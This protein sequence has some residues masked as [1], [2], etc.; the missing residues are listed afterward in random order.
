MHKNIKK[1]IFFSSSLFL[2]ILFILIFHFSIKNIPFVEEANGKLIDMKY[3]H[4][5]NGENQY[6]NVTY[7][8]GKDITAIRIS[9]L[10]DLNRI[11]RVNYIPDKFIYPD[12]ISKDTQIVDL[13]KP[14]EFSKKGTLIF[15][16]L[17]LDP[18]SEDFIEQSNALSKYKIGDYWKFT[19]SLPQIFSASNIYLKSSL[20]AKNGTIKD[21]DFIEYTTSYDE[22]SEKFAAETKDTNIDL[23]F[24]TRREGIDSTIRS[25][26]TIT[27][28]YEAENTSFS[29]MKDYPVIGTNEAI[30]QIQENNYTL[31]LS[32]AFLAIIVL[33]ILLVLSILKHSK[34]FISAILWMTGIILILFAYFTV[35]QTTTLPLLWKALSSSA[36]FLTISGALLGIEIIKKKVWIKYIFLGLMC[37]GALLAF[38]CPYVPFHIATILTWLQYGIRGIGIISIISLLILLIFKKDNFQDYFQLICSTLIAIETFTSLFLPEKFPVSL[39]PSFW[40]NVVT[41]FIT[42]ISVFLIFRETEKINSYLTNNLHLEVERQ[43]EDLKSVVTERNNLLQ[44]VS[45]DMKKPLTSSAILID[46][47]LEREK[48]IEQVKT[49][50]IVKQNTSKVITNLSEIG[51]YAKFN[52]LAEPSSVVNLYDIAL[53]LY[54]FHLPDCNANG[55]LLKNNI[56]KDYRV[57]VKKQ[58][59]ENAISNI[60]LNAVEHANCSTIILSAKINKNRIILSVADDGIGID[61]S[62]QVFQAYADQKEKTGGVGLFICKN[63]IESM[64]GELSY[65]SEK[66]KTV[67]YISLLKA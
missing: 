23:R 53:S 61:S 43:L 37:V 13:S 29:G 2:S 64:N 40:L 26:Q 19:I 1:I 12:K 35:G 50:R 51:A 67:F 28:H 32:F 14:Y 16:I 46:N 66:G 62:I 17:N 38:L 3:T 5:P 45:H 21:Y 9:N 59:L 4:L 57:Y 11:T 39:N 65:T 54:E 47:L 52:Y 24:Y 58:G 34:K 63:I 30:Q 8:L 41:I 20:V 10:K 15:Y 60:I 18:F 33:A 6:E 44:F 25:V 55:I 42:F 7:E 27:I 48:D 49:L 31:I 22:K 56:V 36:V